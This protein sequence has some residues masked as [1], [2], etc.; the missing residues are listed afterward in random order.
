MLQ[1]FRGKKIYLFYL[2]I[3]L[4]LF[5]QQAGAG[6]WLAGKLRKLTVLP[7]C[8][9]K[10][11][12]SVADYFSSKKS[13]FLNAKKLQKEK[14]WLEKEVSRLRLENYLL[15]QKL[16][17]LAFAQNLKNLS[18]LAVVAKTIG[19]SPEQSYFY[20]IIDRGKDA[21]LK[22]NDVVL[23]GKGNLVGKVVQ[24]ITK[25]S[26][27]VELITNPLSAVGAKV[28][29]AVGVLKGRGSKLCFIDYVYLSALPEEG[30][31][32]YTSGYDGIFPE[33]IP[34]GKVRKVI[35][36]EELFGEIYVKPFFKLENLEYVVVLK[37]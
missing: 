5:S 34:I 25:K 26:S 29:R 17:R 32:V 8:V 4:F 20:I 37:R 35:S 13:V 30:Q 33:G 6:K 9:A 1:I 23:D 2:L 36:S 21:G 12:R 16:K 22:E 7:I 18:K 14:D 27:R 28:G 3:S 15:K 24:P 10:G 19:L 31:V 11:I